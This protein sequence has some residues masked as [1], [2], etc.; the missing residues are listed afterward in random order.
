MK[1]KYNIKKGLGNV[2]STYT[3]NL[4]SAVLITFIIAMIQAPLQAQEQ[5]TFTKPSWWFGVAAGANFNFYQGSTQ[6]LNADLTVPAA[7]G[8]GFGVGLFLAPSIEYYRPGSLWGMM[9]Q[10]GLDSRKGEFDE[11][12]SVCNCPMDLST[13]LSYLT[14]EP[15]LRFTPFR[16]DFY[17]YAGPRLAFNMDKSFTYQLHPNPAFPE[18]VMLPEETGDFSE[19]K[20]TIISMQIGAGY[21]IPLSSQNNKTQFVLSPFVAFH[22]YFGQSP[23]S[24]ETWNIT[25]IRAGAILKF[26]IGKNTT[27][28][29]EEDDVEIIDSKV[30]FT[31]NAPENIPS[32]RTVVETF[33]V[34]NYVFFD[35]GS[36]EIPNRYV[37]LKKEDVKDFKE[38][39]VQLFTP[40]N[41]SGRSERQMV[42]YYNILNI[43][44]DRMVKNPGTNI[45]LVGSSEKGIDDAKTMAESVKGYLTDVFAIAGSRITTEGRNKPKI[46]SEQPGATEELE[47][48]RQGDRR[49]SIE[50]NSPALLIEFH[51][52]PDAPLKPVKIVNVQEAPVESYVSFKNEGGAD[53]FTSWTLEIE[54]DNGK[55]QNFGPYT[56]DVVTIPGKTIMGTRPEGV[57]NVKMTGITKEGLTVVKET[58]TKMVLW[59]PSKN[60]EAMRFSVPYNFNDSESIAMYNT[61]LTEVVTPKIP[62][63]G[64]VIIHGHTDVIGDAAYNQKLSVARANDVHAIIKQALAKT[65]RTDVTFEVHGFGEEPNLSQFN[66]KHPEERFYNRTVIIDII[67]RK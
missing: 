31:V 30:N 58:S 11:T 9:L 22:P 15:S 37:L 44:G 59:T 47:L 50:S 12:L 56:Q 26:G 62:T 57:Y 7:F 45:K 41:L 34:I 5:D 4:K 3:L 54:D 17:L 24:T 42:V 46:P 51:S 61:Y 66:N 65:G 20:N 39:N 36:T 16:N 10:F 29:E 33:P 19:V 40:A 64:K 25:T 48:L 60:E 32:E 53:A 8:D 38:E 52:G 14:I 67:P 6:Q 63:S 1:T 27:I 2:W 23:R 21:D 55:K 13:N 35:L 18:Q 49:V 28:E 43:L